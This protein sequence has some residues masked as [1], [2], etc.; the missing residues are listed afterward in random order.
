MSSRAVLRHRSGAA[1]AAT[2]RSSSSVQISPRPWRSRRR[3]PKSRSRTRGRS[4]SGGQA[5]AVTGSS[6][7]ARASIRA[8]LGSSAGSARRGATATRSAIR[9]GGAREEEEPHLEGEHAGNDADDDGAL[10]WA[11]PVLPARVLLPLVTHAPQP[12]R[13]VACGGGPPGDLVVL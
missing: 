9:Q 1:Q 13:G 7:N 5:Q 4:S 12:G 6:W 10:D 2:L 11:D 8:S 3:I